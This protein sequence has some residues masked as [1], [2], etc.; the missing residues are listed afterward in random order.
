MQEPLERLERGALTIVEALMKQGYEAYLVGGCVRDK[1]L[2]RKVKDYDIAT[3][4]KPEQV[5]SAFARTIPTG[6]QHGTVTV[7]I[8]GQPYEVTTFRKEDAYEDHRRPAGV[9]YIDSLYEDLRRRDFTMNAM[10]LDLEGRLI[11]PF[12]GRAD[13]EQGIL[14][15]V[16]EAKERFEEDALRILRC[17]RFAAEYSMEVEGATW[18]A[19]LAQVHLL[20]HIAMERVRMELE[21]MIAGAAPVK[22]V[23]LL[24]ASGALRYCK[25]PLLLADVSP[26][27]LSEGLAQLHSP[28]ERWAYMYLQL[29]AE[30]K[31]VEEELRNL[32]FSNHQVE[33]VRLIIAAARNVAGCLNGDP[34][35]EVTASSYGESWKLAAVRFGKQAVRSLGA[36]LAIDEDAAASAGIESGQARSLAG[37]SVVWLDEMPVGKTVELQVNGGELISH[38]GKPAGPW[39]APVLQHLLRAAAL[40]TIPNSKEALLL[41][42]RR[43]DQLTERERDE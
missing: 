32:T 40:G 33:E 41:E 3:S 16:G 39:V 28:L 1:L 34:A 22:A 19:L 14:R 17:I 31:A 35:G 8:E 23:K 21:R 6:L 15:C 10:A 11:D 12:H 18:E 5:K 43:Y 37:G 30:A 7:V 29:G 20:K 24:A 42:A 9:E 2:S 4:A 27:R 38:I 13:M 36:I 26:D 25:L